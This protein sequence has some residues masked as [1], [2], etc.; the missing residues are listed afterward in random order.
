MA[1]ETDTAKTLEDIEA[2]L[3][4]AKAG[5]YNFTEAQNTFREP[6]KILQAIVKQEPLNYNANYLLADVMLYL[7]NQHPAIQYLKKCFNLK[8]DNHFLLQ[9]IQ[10]I[11]ATIKQKS[12]DGLD[13][14]FQRLE[15]D[16]KC[17]AAMGCLA[18]QYTVMGNIEEALNWRIRAIDTDPNDWELHYF[19][20]YTYRRLKQ[21]DKCI[22]SLK[23]ALALFNEPVNPDNPESDMKPDLNKRIGE[24][25]DE[26][27]DYTTAETY[28]RLALDLAHPDNK[29]YYYSELA[30]NLKHQEKYPEAI[31]YYQ[32]LQAADTKDRYTNT[33]S[34]IGFCYYQLGDKATAK[35]YYQQAAI[36][37]PANDNTFYSL[38]VLF[39]EDGDEEMAKM[40]YEMALQ[41]NG[42]NLQAH[43][44]MGMI[45]F[46]ETRYK[47]A[48]EHFSRVVELNIF[49]DTA[50]EMLYRAYSKLTEDE[51]AEEALLR[52]IVIKQ[53]I[54]KKDEKE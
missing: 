25:Y 6:V 42:N 39:T 32:L 3:A 26:M 17:T 10:A 38:G 43:Y 31:E 24:V 2:I 30:D 52:S 51:K 54:N 12:I 41:A 27:K 13:H 23:M 47:L 15:E 48:V 35:K 7:D 1:A 21:F 29:I 40:M 34:L 53:I 22:D 49:N 44:N 45:A 19:A 50:Y 16:P 28:F 14:Q 33:D 5:P 37:D 8:P 46:R 18:Q 4:K 36:K 9:E 20:Y 11:E